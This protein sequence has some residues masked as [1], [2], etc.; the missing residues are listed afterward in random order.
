SCALRHPQLKVVGVEFLP[1]RRS[2]DLGCAT[3]IAP[4]EETVTV[5]KLASGIYQMIA[6][7][8]GPG[9]LGVMGLKSFVVGSGTVPRAEI[10]ILPPA[11]TVNDEIKIRISCTTSSSFAPR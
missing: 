7:F 9:R 2:S 8:A 5:G 6:T 11:P 3:V 10:E 1:T 4:W